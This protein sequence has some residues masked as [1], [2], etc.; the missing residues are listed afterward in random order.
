MRA[1]TPV[2]RGRCTQRSGTVAVFRVVSHGDENPALLRAPTD[3]PVC[4]TRLVVGDE[5][6]SGERRAE[7]CGG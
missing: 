2:T 3:D 7:L 5:E 1:P 6:L 4:T